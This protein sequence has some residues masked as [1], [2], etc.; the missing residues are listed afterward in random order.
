MRK[1]SLIFD[2]GK[3]VT[4]EGVMCSLGNND[5][6]VWI[7]KIENLTMSQLGSQNIFVL[8]LS[9]VRLFATLGTVSRQAPLSLGILQARILKWVTISYSRGSS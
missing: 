8:M 2:W 4:K 6:M 1:F 3:I 7:F 9:I 5:H